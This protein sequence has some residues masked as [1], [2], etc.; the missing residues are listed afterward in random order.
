MFSEFFHK[1]GFLMWPLLLCSILGFAI[2]ADRFWALA[3]THLN[4]RLFLKKLKIHLRSSQA[5]QKPS[6]LSSRPASASLMTELYYAYLYQPVEKRTEALRREGLQHLDELGSRLR[7]LSA[8][9]QVAPLLGLLGTVTGLVAAFYQLQNL[10]GQAQPMDLA[11]GIWEA[12]I[13]TV[14]GLSIGIP[15]LLAYQYIQAKIDRRAHEMT[16]VVS[17][18]DEVFAHSNTPLPLKEHETALS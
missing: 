4:F 10:G 12:L 11:G 2:I 8:I 15:S 13:T 6:F 16:Q 7:L 3:W 9:A 1:G 17:Q 5:C 18:L 14:V